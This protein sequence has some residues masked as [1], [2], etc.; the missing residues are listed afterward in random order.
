MF[1]VIIEKHD[2]YLVENTFWRRTSH[3]SSYGSVSAYQEVHGLYVGK[4]SKLPILLM[5]TEVCA[6]VATVIVVGNLIR[7]FW[8]RPKG[9]N[10]D[11]DGVTD[12]QIVCCCHSKCP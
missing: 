10:S 11:K 9:S 6:G 8:N 7:L 1:L 12:S 2:D 3:R 5:I 4:H